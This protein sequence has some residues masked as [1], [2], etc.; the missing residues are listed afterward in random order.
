M[1]QIRGSLVE[2][3]RDVLKILIFEASFD[4]SCP[5]K[6]GSDDSRLMAVLT[7]RSGEENY[8]KSPH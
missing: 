5:Q 7:G 6:S 4:G 8:Q 2:E 3:A 1:G